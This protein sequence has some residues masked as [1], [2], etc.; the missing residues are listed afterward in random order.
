MSLTSSEDVP[1]RDAGQL[2]ALVPGRRCDPA[3]TID[4]LFSRWHDDH[5]RQAREALFERF[6]P[7]AR[8]L[9]HRYHN[10]HEP[11]EDLIQVAGVG[12]LYAIDRF[13]PDRGTHFSSFAIPTI[14]GELKRHFRTTAWTV[15]VPRRPQELALRVEHAVR[16]LSDRRGRPPAPA[17]LAEFLKID[18]ADVL[19]GLEAG[20]AHF[21][22]SLDAPTTTSDVPEPQLL[23]ESFGCHEEGYDLVDVTLSL[24]AAIVRLPRR[25]QTVLRL[26]TERDLK[27]SEIAGK[28]GCSQMQVSRLLRAATEH[29]R[30]QID[31]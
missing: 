9:A 4:R 25:E 15:H 18:V 26:R 23:G 24:A 13:D 3:I 14:I 12:L 10:P 27:Q 28:I 16:E 11:L 2:R 7:L 19:M 20:S 29:L 21:S 5:D 30:Q 31:P 8:G 6:L 17:E 1:R 22:A